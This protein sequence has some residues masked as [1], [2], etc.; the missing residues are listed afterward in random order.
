MIAWAFYWLIWT[1]LLLTP[2]Q[3]SSAMYGSME[4][5]YADLATLITKVSPIKKVYI[6]YDTLRIDHPLALVQVESTIDALSTK[7]ASLRYATTL[8]NLQPL[9]VVSQEVVLTL[10][11]TVLPLATSLQACKTL[12]LEPL[13][14][15][16]LP[17]ALKTSIPI[18]LHDEIS[19]GTDSVLCISPKYTLREDDCLSSILNKT[20]HLLPFE[21]KEELRNYL[22]NS[23]IGTVAHI[24][25]SSEEAVFTVN[26]YGNSACIGAY[27]PKKMSKKAILDVKLL[28]EHFY[29]KL[30][31]A[32][33]DIYD[34]LDLIVSHLGDTIHSISSDEFTLPIPLQSK[35][36][37]VEEII[38]LMPLYLENHPNRIPTYPIFEEFF[39]Q[40]IKE[41]PDYVLGD[42]KAEDISRLTD[43]QRKILYSSLIQ[44]REGLTR[45]MTEYMKAFNLYQQTL[46]LPRTLLFVPNQNP[47][48][49][50]YLIRTMIPSID[51]NLLTEILII[52]QNEKA[53]LL[54]DVSFLFKNA[55]YVSH[56]TRSKFSKLSRKQWKKYSSTV[57]GSYP[58]EDRHSQLN[59]LHNYH[60]LSDL[61][62]TKNDTSPFT[63]HGTEVHVKSHGISKV[64]MNLLSPNGKKPRSTYTERP[65][66]PE[67]HDNESNLIP[68]IKVVRNKRSWGSFWGGLFS[69]ASQED[70]DQVYSH[71]LAIGNNELAKSTS[72][73]NITDSNSHL[74]NSVQ[75]VSASVNSLLAR[76]KNLFS[77]IH[78][79]MSKEE[80]TL[81]NFNSVF[82]TLDRSTSLISEYLTLQT[83]TTLLFNSIQKI[84]ALVLSVL[85]STL[86]VSQIPTSVL[87]PH[88]TSNIKLSLS[89]VKASFIY[90]PEGY[91]IKF[92]IPKLTRPYTVYY[93]QTVPFLRK[94]MWL[95]L[96]I[97]KFLVMNGIH[98]TIEYEEAREACIPYQENYICPPDVLHQGHLPKNNSCSYQLVLSKLTES[99]PN[100]KTCF[101]VRLSKMTEQRFLMKNEE[102]II[103]SPKEDWLQYHCLDQSKNGQ[104]ALKIGVNRM[105][106]L[107]GCQYE[108]SQLQLRNPAQSSI[109]IS[110]QGS[111][112][113]LNI[114]KNLDSLD[115]ILQDQLPK[116]VN[117]TALH[118]D[119]IKYNIHEES[120]DKSIDE[121]S[122]EVKNLESIRTMSE[123]SPINL[124]LSRPFHTSNWVAC[125]FWI[126]TVM[127]IAL[128]CS[129]VRHCGWYKKIAKPIWTKI[130]KAMKSITI[131][132]CRC[133]KKNPTLKEAYSSMWKIYDPTNKM[134]RQDLNREQIELL[135]PI[136]DQGNVPIP[137][138]SS[139]SRINPAGEKW[140]TIQALYGNWQMRA[141]LQD[142]QQKPCPIYYNP[143]SRL[144]T[145][146]EGRVLE[147]VNRPSNEDIEYFYQ[148]VKNSKNPP[149]VT[150]KGVIKHKSYPNL[151]YNTGLKVWMN[152]ETQSSVP[153]L[154]APKGFLLYIPK[155]E[156]ELD[157][158]EIS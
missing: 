81:E 6:S 24:I 18:L 21:K 132:V 71:E 100:L 88:L 133:E 32:F 129:I 107:N 9:T 146:Q 152:E 75:T 121:I 74:L 111:D 153:G 150:D 40:S 33:T 72:L 23:F 119:L 65:L 13:T 43:R 31:S 94:D 29:E 25:V 15:F 98:E 155:T 76:E 143:R 56:L 114:V 106:S 66:T 59:F 67:N 28:H 82:T 50:L 10:F 52:L 95:S 49:F 115:S 83:Q 131:A 148:I 47:S 110:E 30:N 69:L 139:L 140:K 109:T 117:L 116:E 84:Q 97:P 135:N 27:N 58:I 122:K 7:L 57:T 151:Y 37:S 63:E 44:F 145:S 86:D 61:T 26:P 120:A 2:T 90:T 46:Y 101:A 123:F 35:E 42:L 17:I 20:R 103:S 4:P 11:Q 48:T 85:T 55:T 149:T 138:L 126:M 39:L 157:G 73:R 62:F 127:A 34:Y 78:A 77:D 54:Q 96:I 93:I 125:I 142:F 68:F 14:L 16:N 22:L 41:S 45:R 124:D 136:L 156:E 158:I 141:V 102:I 144:V 91:Q 80:L 104:R 89:Q 147:D 1:S 112:R 3:E 70:L 51:E 118:L 108:T 92:L 154:N 12:Q 53:S 134:Q 105:P 113:G 19:I 137:D 8:E 99:E 79:I 130:W 128:T 60:N 36:K 38:K 5:V 64:F 87:R